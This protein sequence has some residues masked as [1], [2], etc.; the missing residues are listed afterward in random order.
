MASPIIIVQEH[1]FE[2]LVSFN[3]KSN[4]GLTSWDDGMNIL[5]QHQVM[6]NFKEGGFIDGI[7]LKIGMCV[8]N[9][10]VYVYVE[11]HYNNV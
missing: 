7:T 3:T 5:A 10:N 4:Q 6:G 9:C 2:N 8:H 11:K 1:E